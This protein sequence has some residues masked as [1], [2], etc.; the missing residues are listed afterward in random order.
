MARRKRSRRKIRRKG[1]RKQ[2]WSEREEL[3]A[4]CIALLV[5][6]CFFFWDEGR[7]R[8]HGCF[9]FVAEDFIF[10]FSSSEGVSHSRF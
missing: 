9:M 1:P 3:M 7:R 6:V 10:I 5:K 2:E 4:G 8:L